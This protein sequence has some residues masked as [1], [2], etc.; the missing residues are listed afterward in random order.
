M[1]NDELCSVSVYCAQKVVNHTVCLVLSHHNIGAGDSP[2]SQIRRLRLRIK[3]ASLKIIQLGESVITP[4]NSF[5]IVC[6]FCGS[7]WNA[8]LIFFFV[9]HNHQ[10]TVFSFF[11]FFFKL[12][13]GCEKYSYLM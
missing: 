1:Y 10:Y 4:R 9:A 3:I 7:V 2:I 12:R 6:C 11:F 13:W 5:Q 8:S